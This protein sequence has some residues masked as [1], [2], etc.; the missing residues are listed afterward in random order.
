MDEPRFRDADRA[1]WRRF[2]L[3]PT[4]R[5]L[6]H[7]SL[8]TRIR[9][10]DVGTGAPVILIGGTGGTAAWWAPLVHELPGRRAIAIDRPGWGLGPPLDY[11]T[12]DFGSAVADIVAGVMDA[13]EIDRADVIG[14]SIGGLWAFHA[15][16][17]HAERVGRIVIVGG[18]PH[19]EVA[20]P[21][22]IKL[23]RTPL[24]AV[25]VRLPAREGMLRRQLVALGHGEALARG[26]LDPFIAWR[27]AFDGSTP[28]LRHERA[29]VKAITAGDGMR[30]GVI[31][32]DS[33]LGTVTAPTLMVFGTADPTGNPDLWQRFTAH[34]PD[35]SLHLV[36]RGGHMPFWDD[37]TGVGS[38]VARF[39]DGEPVAAT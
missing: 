26:A 20:L 27:L 19:P 17:R 15:A 23:L 32:N 31:P 21:A 9:A 24:G 7:A 18:M 16:I 4:E 3:E 37:P 10:L 36:E 2:G 22:F 11:R 5:W 30:S 6:D 29:M 28:S 35:A 8:P 1:L 33:A 14:A 13:L 39:L 38:S 34:L 25:L 12:V